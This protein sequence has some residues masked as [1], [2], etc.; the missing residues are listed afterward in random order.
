[1]AAKAIKHALAGVHRKGRCFFSVKRATAPIVLAFPFQW[2]VTGDYLYHIGCAAHLLFKVF[3]ISVHYPLR[4]Q[5]HFTHNLYSMYKGK[6]LFFSKKIF[7]N[8][9]TDSLKIL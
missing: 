4:L 2:H 6:I 5:L 8:A 7:F 3:K 9:C 1:M